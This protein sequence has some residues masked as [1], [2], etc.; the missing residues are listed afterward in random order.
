MCLGQTKDKPGEFVLKRLE[1]GSR[2]VVNDNVLSL[3]FK[4]TSVH[5]S[6]NKDVLPHFL[7]PPSFPKNL[8]GARTPEDAKKWK[9]GINNKKLGRKWEE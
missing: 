8:T 5:E 3:D 1:R 7:T 2:H 6:P 4:E 9:N